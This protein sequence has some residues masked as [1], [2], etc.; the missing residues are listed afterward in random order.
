VDEQEKMISDILKGRSGALR[1][2]QQSRR[3]R[4]FHQCL[5]L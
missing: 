5:R 4:R 1:G 3:L 2:D